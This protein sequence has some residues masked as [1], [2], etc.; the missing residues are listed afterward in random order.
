ML[1]FSI[2][3]IIPCELEG[4]MFT[5]FTVEI[6]TPP[7]NIEKIQYEYVKK[8]IAATSEARGARRE[9]TKRGERSEWLRP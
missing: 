4:P 8:T 3:V 2:C 9:A 6:E 7:C 5:H 1:Y